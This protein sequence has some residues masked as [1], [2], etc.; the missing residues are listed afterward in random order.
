MLHEAEMMQSSPSLLGFLVGSD[1]WPN[2]RATKVYLEALDEMDWPNPIIASASQRGFPKALGPSGMKMDGPYD[3]VPPGYWYGDEGGAFGFGSEL[4]AGVGTP[5]MDSLKTFMS[6]DDLKTLWTEENAGLYHMSSDS[7]AFYDRSIYN[8]ALFA[9]YGK[10]KNLEDYVMKCQ[11][12]DYEATR[13]QFEA[14]SA[15]QNATRPA[16][17]SIYWMLNS[18]W[19]NLHWQLFDYYLRPMGAYFGTKVGAREE[20]V[21]YDYATK[22]VWLINHSIEL[23]GER[24]ILIDLIDSNGKRISN[25]QV[26]T[27]TQPSS[28]KQI[29]DID[30]IE[31]I[32]DVAFLRLM[33]K[34]TIS[35]KTLSRNVYWISPHSD[36]LDW[37]KSNWYYTPVTQ[38]SN[39]T[40]M[41]NLHKANVKQTV[42]DIT[43]DFK[44]E[45]EWSRAAIQLE[46]KS[47]RPAVFL[48]LMAIDESTGKEITPV[49]FSDNYITL[50]PNE[51][52]TLNVLLKGNLQNVSFNIS[53]RNLE[54]QS[55]RISKSRN[56]KSRR[57][58]DI[59]ES[60]IFG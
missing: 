10:P 59:I 30:G 27:T 36:V 34:D 38:F 48:R 35:K 12:A 47:H 32:K 25:S 23:Q 49:F 40:K 15:N 22:S 33:L 52:I 9:R 39:Y 41:E 8:K 46:N 54:S 50:W 29:H 56:H 28:S 44:T 18:A 20:N 60:M 14:F 5:E 21:A 11:M 42:R 58:S 7:S 2:D 57:A 24:E 43:K 3:W 19:P 55:A 53:G 37:E 6:A 45:A 16:T 31:K 51:K 17:G 1:Y 13:A 4:G 26:K